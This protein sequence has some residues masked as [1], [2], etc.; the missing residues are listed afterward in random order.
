M[1]LHDT[2]ECKAFCL[3]L[4]QGTV[5]NQILNI[6]GI[7]FIKQR[8][9]GIFNSNSRVELEI[10]NDMRGYTELWQYVK[11]SIVKTARSILL[12]HATIQV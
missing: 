12:T 6:K 7:S 10:M 3:K 9:L 4:Y 2:C 8:L 5:N 1:R 11:V